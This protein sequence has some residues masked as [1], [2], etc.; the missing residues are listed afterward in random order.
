VVERPDG[1]RANVLP[2]PTPICDAT[3]AMIGAVNMLV[4]ITERKQ[5]EAALEELREK[6]RRANMS[7]LQ[8]ARAQRRRY[9]QLD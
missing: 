1:T 2:Y 5:T 9:A 4:D 6:V 8:N 3:G 7:S